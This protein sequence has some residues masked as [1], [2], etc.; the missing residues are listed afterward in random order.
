MTPYEKSPNFIDWLIAPPDGASLGAI[1]TLATVLLFLVVAGTLFAY[2]ITALQVGLSEAFYSVS[3]A[4][5]RG[6]HESSKPR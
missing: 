1:I 5:G 6:F 2:F 4:I 3:R